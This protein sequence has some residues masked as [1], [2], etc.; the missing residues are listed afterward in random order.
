V[1]DIISRPHMAGKMTEYRNDL[2]QRLMKI[3]RLK[4]V[5][6]KWTKDKT[7]P[8]YHAPIKHEANMPYAGETVFLI[9]RRMPSEFMA[10]LVMDSIPKEAHLIQVYV[11]KSDILPTDNNDES[12]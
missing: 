5:Q 6:I 8:G 7:L 11:Q 9:P 2:A 12:A 10:H 3:R 1:S 4:K